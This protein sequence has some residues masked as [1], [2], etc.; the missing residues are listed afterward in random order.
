MPL[1]TKSSKADLVQDAERLLHSVEANPDSL[2]GVAEEKAALEA[3]LAEVR[4]LITRQLNAIGEK[5]KATQELRAAMR[6]MLD[7]TIQLRAVI[8]A[9]LGPRTEKL[10]EYLVSPLRPRRRKASASTPPT[11]PTPDGSEQPP[12]PEEPILRS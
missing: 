1:N 12:R 11:T 2:A 4:T 9:K 7:L 3:G 6:R 10:V 5:Q 8:K